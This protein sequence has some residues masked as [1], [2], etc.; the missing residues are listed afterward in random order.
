MKLNVLMICNA[1]VAGVFGIA[2]AL[3]P[4]W[5]VSLYGV[6]PDAQLGYVAQLFGAALIVLAVVTWMARDAADSDARQAI[7]VGLA[8]GDSVGFVVALIGQLGA[9]VNPLGWSSVAIYG[10]LAAGFWSAAL[11]R[12]ASPP[13]AA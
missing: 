4:G 11:R 9:V 5:V 7:V 1:I 13:S 2:F 6:A 8:V 10:L 3:A 12:T